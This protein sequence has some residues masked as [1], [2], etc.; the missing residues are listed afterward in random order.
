ML[1]REERQRNS[2]QIKLN[3]AMTTS[4][5]PRKKI[6]LKKIGD[7]QEKLGDNDSAT[8]QPPSLSLNKMQSSLPLKI[9][10]S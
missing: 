5:A 2:S 9:K 10:R 4:G 1:N 7:V 3:R 8:K 6:K